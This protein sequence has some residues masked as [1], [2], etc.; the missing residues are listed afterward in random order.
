MTKNLKL[1]LA[2]IAAT[3][4][5]SVSARA[6]IFSEIG[7]AGNV[8]PAANLTTAGGIPA[9]NS[10]TAITGTIS[11]SGDAD[12]FAIFI[13]NAALFSATTVNAATGS[14]DTQLFLFNASGNPV[15]AND[16]ANGTTLG[17]TLPAGSGFPLSAGLY[18]LAISLSG[19]DAV[20]AVNQLLFATS[21]DSTALRGPAFGA[22][23]PLGGFFN[24]G[25]FGSGGYEIDLTGVTAIP[26]PS[27]G[28]LSLVAA[29]TLGAAGWARRRRSRLA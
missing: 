13:S 22:S 23:G 21:G 12:V 19:N 11:T 5:G 1:I 3:S 7:D 2:I 14:L 16:D 24:N 28:M 26:E 27:V 29:T 10:L 25:A 9:G 6:D 17:S 18:Y 4:L 8:C 20:N 15:F